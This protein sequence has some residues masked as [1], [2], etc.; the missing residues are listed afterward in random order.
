[1]GAV[2]AFALH[3]RARALVFIRGGRR[4]RRRRRT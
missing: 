4:R 1:L 2:V 3:F